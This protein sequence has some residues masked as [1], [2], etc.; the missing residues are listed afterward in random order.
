MNG[1]EKVQ[2][3]KYKGKTCQWVFD[4]DYKYALWLW[5]DSNSCTKTKKA[6]QS[7]M[8]KSITAVNIFNEKQ[9]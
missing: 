8:D 6:I 7:L 5:K 4:N 9:K 2:F 3:G 1:K